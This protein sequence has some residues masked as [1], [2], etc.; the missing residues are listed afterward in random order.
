[1]LVEKQQA[2]KKENT[3]MEYKVFEAETTL[4]ESEE[5]RHKAAVERLSPVAA[6]QS[7]GDIKAAEDKSAKNIMLP[8]ARVQNWANSM[9]KD[10]NDVANS[11]QKEK[12][13]NHEKNVIAAANKVGE[14]LAKGE[15][16]LK[17]A[18]ALLENAP[19]KKKLGA[20]H[21]D[22]HVNNGGN[23]VWPKVMPSMQVSGTEEELKPKPVPFKRVAKPAA[24]VAAKH[25]DA[26]V[27]PRSPQNKAM[28]EEAIRDLNVFHSDPMYQH[29]LGPSED[30]ELS[31]QTQQDLKMLHQALGKEYHR[32]DKPVGK[33]AVQ[34]AVKKPVVAKPA[35]PRVAPQPSAHQQ[36]PPA[37]KPVVQQ[38]VAPKPVA[39]NP[40]RK[41]AVAKPA[42]VPPMR[43]PVVPQPTAPKAPVPQRV[44]AAPQHTQPVAAPV[45]VVPKIVPKV[46]PNHAVPKPI[47][48]A[49]PQQPQQVHHQ[50]IPAQVHSQQPPAVHQQPVKPVQKV[51]LRHPPAS[52]A[53]KPRG[54]KLWAPE[55]EGGHS[56]KKLSREEQL[57]AEVAAEQTET[58]SEMEKELAA[59]DEE[60]SAPVPV[61]VTQSFSH[62]AKSKGRKL[63]IPEGSGTK[64]VPI[65]GTPSQGVQGQMVNHED[66]K[67]YTKDWGNEYGQH[68]MDIQQEAAPPPP[69]KGGA[70]T[71]TV[72]GLAIVLLA[73]A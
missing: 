63:G 24:P 50:Q 69:V 5:N 70:A 3:G 6:G 39:A 47:V 53:P 37:P 49:H 46:A 13:E 64:T 32:F 60:F 35:V 22:A 16:T 73:F 23:N 11:M 34:S 17:K 57:E 58:R 41:P 25:A 36:L 52:A 51:A 27:T 43:K 68:H 29:L 40:V 12:M 15:Q 59:P 19:K 62:F 31:A 33:P 4:G 21:K 18:P 38:Q 48:P 1:M 56:K 44:A 45:H 71:W 30:P 66:G 8:A 2:P 65:E 61:K 54:A 7:W 28:Q 10:L 55:M 20:V 14:V 67:T 42:V 9:S 26:S 72:S